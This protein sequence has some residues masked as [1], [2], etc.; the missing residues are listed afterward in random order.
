MTR[1]LSGCRVAPYTKCNLATLLYE[2][3]TPSETLM[4]PV[5]LTLLFNKELTVQLMQLETQLS[6]N[7]QVAF[8]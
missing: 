3:A 8:R 6:S 4:K 5:G 2:N 1:K 7:Q